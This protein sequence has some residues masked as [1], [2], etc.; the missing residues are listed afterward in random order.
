MLSS[1][2]DGLINLWTIHTNECEST[3]DGHTDKVWALD[4][5]PCDTALFSGGEDSKIAVWRDA[6]KERQEAVREAEEQNIV[7][8]QQLSNHLR[9][10][11]YEQA[12]DIAQELDKPNQVLRVLNEIVEKDTKDGR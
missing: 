4:L 12:L 2:S 11:N 1:G 9:H 10:K 5:S 3:I 6:T 7:M 8:E